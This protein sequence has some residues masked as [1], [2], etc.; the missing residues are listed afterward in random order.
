EDLRGW[1]LFGLLCLGVFGLGFVMWVWGMDFLIGGDTGRTETNAII[2]MVASPLMLLAALYFF[3]LAWRD[4]RIMVRFRQDNLTGEGVVTHRWIDKNASGRK[5]YCVGYQYG[6]NHDAYQEV[7][8]RR[9]DFLAIGDKI[10]VN[11]LPDDPPLGYF[12]PDK[13]KAKSKRKVEE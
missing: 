5:V 7:G 1:V 4:W 10:R 12:E 6:D 8:K 13:R 2:I 3:Y 11:Y 9:Y